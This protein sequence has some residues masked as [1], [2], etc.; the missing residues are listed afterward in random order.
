M[1]PDLSQLRVLVLAGGESPERDVSLESGRCVSDSLRSMGINVSQLDPAETEISQLGTDE[2][3]IVFPV[4]H[5]TGGEDGILQQQLREVGLPYVG[6]SPEASAL[7][8][9]KHATRQCVAQHGIHVADAIIVTQTDNV[10]DVAAQ[11]LSAW[12]PVVVKPSRQGSSV[13]I[14][15]VR[16]ADQLKAAI[17]SALTYDQ[18]CLIENYIDGRELTVAVVD[19]IALPTVEI[20]VADEWYDYHAKYSDDRTQYIVQPDRIPTQ[21]T[22]MAKKACGVCGVS[23]I[24]RVDFRLDDSEKLWLLEVNSVPGMTSHSLVPKAASAIGQ[25][26]GELCLQT[27]QTQ[28]NRMTGVFDDGK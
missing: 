20:V 13:G 14:T 15:I 23:G 1:Q 18:T 11:L 21:V 19:G 16:K 8:F 2:W 12:R 7:T 4:V 6:S 9:D 17:A 24:A 27:I 22:S 3:D 5:G 10:D 25:S 26:L 28:L